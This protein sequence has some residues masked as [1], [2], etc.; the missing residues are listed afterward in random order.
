MRLA[1]SFIMNYG[2]PDNVILHEI[3]DLTHNNQAVR[4][5]VDL[6]ASI[7]TDHVQGKRTK[8]K[9]IYK[10][11]MEVCNSGWSVTTLQAALWAFNI[12]TDYKSGL[13]QAVNLGGD[14]DTIGAVYGQIAGAYYGVSAIPQT[15]VKA[16]KT[17]EK[18]NE[19]IEAT[20]DL[21]LANLTK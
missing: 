9:S 21:K 6:M 15:W 19:L 12:T 7:L 5:T 10:N 13:I 1:P 16:V 17:Y 4:D 11:K 14:A 18:V 20:I 2:A 8:Q 3:S